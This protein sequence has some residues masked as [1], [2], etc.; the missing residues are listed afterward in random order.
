MGQG[1]LEIRE[2]S[3]E[4]VWNDAATKHSTLVL[5]FIKVN[6]SFSRVVR[7]SGLLD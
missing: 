5:S 2:K 3:Q 6:S 7:V 1:E 4:K